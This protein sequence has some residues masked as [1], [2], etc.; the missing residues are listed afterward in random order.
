[1]VVSVFEQMKRAS[2]LLVQVVQQQMS[3][4]CGDIDDGLDRDEEAG[5]KDGQ[6]K[7][8]SIFVC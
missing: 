5:G 6:T 1:M 8:V 7:T 3:P 4:V 2:S